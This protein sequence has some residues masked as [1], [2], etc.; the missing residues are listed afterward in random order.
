MKYL[1]FI[2]G[3]IVIAGAAEI[4]DQ[5]VK[6]A[7]REQVSQAYWCGKADWTGIKTQSYDEGFESLVKSGNCKDMRIKGWLPLIL[8]WS[9]Q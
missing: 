7:T 8:R 1:I 2:I 6:V 4:S 9:G 3:A 5:A